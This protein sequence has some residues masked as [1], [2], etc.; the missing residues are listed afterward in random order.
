ML[1]S[2]FTQHSRSLKRTCLLVHPGHFQPKVHRAQAL[3]VLSQQAVDDQY[4]KDISGRVTWQANRRNK[5]A[6]YLSYNNTCHCHFL[7]GRAKSAT[8]GNSKASPRLPI[9]NNVSQFT[10]SSPMTNKLLVEAGFSYI[11]EDQQFNPRPESVVP[12]IS[13]SGKNITSRAT[14]SNLRA[15]TPVY[16]SRGSMAYV[17]GSHAFK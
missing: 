5:I 9:P 8:R 2:L 15:Y 16:G 10:W 4:S 14:S 3:P 12:Q 11:L 13:D 6:A 7:I 1:E 17:T